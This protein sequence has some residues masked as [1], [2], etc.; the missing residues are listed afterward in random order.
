MYSVRYGT[1]SI[2]NGAGGLAVAVER[3][4]LHRLGCDGIVFREIRAGG[5]PAA[6]WQLSGSRLRHLL[7]VSGTK[8]GGDI[9]RRPACGGA[10]RG[11]VQPWSTSEYTGALFGRAQRERCGDPRVLGRVNGS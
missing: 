8:S 7:F 3:R 5:S 4:G 6:L 1:L 9:S 2:V 10:S 11:T